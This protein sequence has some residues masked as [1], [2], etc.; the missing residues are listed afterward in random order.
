MKK[1]SNSNLKYLKC[2]KRKCDFLKHFIHKIIGK[3]T[4]LWPHLHSGKS[5]NSATICKTCI[6]LN[7]LFSFL[8]IHETKRKI[9]LESIVNKRFLY[10]WYIKCCSVY[11][12]RDWAIPQEET[13]LIKKLLTNPE[14]EGFNLWKR[15]RC[16]IRSC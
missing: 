6:K 11:V 16:P 9:N 4:F 14:L 8:Y 3:L 1:I 5:G 10:S 15:S 7:L 12:L 13:F 2:F